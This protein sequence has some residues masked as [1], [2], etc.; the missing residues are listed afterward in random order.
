M[1]TSD[2]VIPDF[3]EVQAAAAKP[4]T[5]EWIARGFESLRGEISDAQLEDLLVGVEICRER[6][7][8][9]VEQRE[10][11]PLL[12]REE[13]ALA[14]FSF[15]NLAAQHVGADFFKFADLEADHPEICNELREIGKRI[16]GSSGMRLGEF[17][18]CFFEVITLIAKA[19]YSMTLPRDVFECVLEIGFTQEQV[20]AALEKL[21]Q[22][23]DG[24]QSH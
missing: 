19:R 6:Y 13:I 18:F 20:D 2:K 11:N 16:D 12:P 14:K 15:F 8:I 24:R 23:M 22:Q 17:L 1:N 21:D 10:A 9:P 5:W 3:D 4:E 7:S